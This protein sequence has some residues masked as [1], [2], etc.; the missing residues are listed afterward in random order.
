M[1]HCLLMKFSYKSSSVKCE[2]IKVLEGNSRGTYT[3]GIPLKGTP[4]MAGTGDYDDP[5]DSDIEAKSY[6]LF[7]PVDTSGK[8]V[9]ITLNADTLTKGW[10]GEFTK[11]DPANS[12][13]LQTSGGGATGTNING[14]SSLTITKQY[15]APQVRFDGQYFYIK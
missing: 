2:L 15:D 3:I 6:R 14:A 11:L 7:Y 5:V 8:D 4:K 12:L 13:I 1:M 10:T 9:T